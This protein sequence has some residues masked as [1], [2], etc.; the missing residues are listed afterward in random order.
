MSEPETP[1]Q[2]CCLPVQCVREQELKALEELDPE[3]SFAI[4]ET[5]QKWVD[6]SVLTYYFFDEDTDGSEQKDANGQVSWISWRGK[7]HQKQQ[8]RQAF[9]AWKD[10]GINLEFKEV[11][12]R[13]NAVIR[14]GF[15]EGDGSWSYVGTDCKTIKDPNKRT[16]NIGWN[17]SNDFTTYLHEVGHALGLT[18]EHQSAKAGIVWNNKKVYEYFRGHPNYWQ[19]AEIKSNILDKVHADRVQASTWDPDSCMHYPFDQGLIDQ[20]E[21]Y[22]TQPLTPKGG[23]SARDKEWV[24][25]FYPLPEEN[26]SRRSTESNG[27]KVMQPLKLEIKAGQ[28]LNYPLSV[29][30]TREYHIQRSGESDAVMVLFENTLEGWKQVTAVDDSGQAGNALLQVILDQEKTYN[31]RVRLYWEGKPGSTIITLW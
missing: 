20:P 21:K 31:L 29:D 10:L 23:L 17:E 2:F 24:K 4:L 22:R 8:I 14:V 7:D 6:G 9:K 5:Y 15:M 18:H 25:A 1:K 30:E 27:L 28:Q 16:M 26:P 12:D 19:D 3:R 13:R 11:S